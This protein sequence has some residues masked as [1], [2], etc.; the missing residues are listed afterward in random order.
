MGN[1]KIKNK[2]DKIHND[3]IEWLVSVYNASIDE[4]VTKDAYEKLIEYGLTD[5]QIK[6]IFEKTKSEEFLSKAFDKAWARQE[7]RNE[8]EK[9]SLIEMIKIFF[10][11]PYELFGHF[12]S[13]LRVLWDYNYKTK[14]R[15]RLILLILG[16][17]FWV[18]FF[19]IN[20]VYIVY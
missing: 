13:G 3:E 18:L 4:E 2:S 12:N 14:F 10:L 16:T 11:S 8:F 19:V 6:D 15:Q 17:F 1:K 9:Y 5:K 7:E 20:Y